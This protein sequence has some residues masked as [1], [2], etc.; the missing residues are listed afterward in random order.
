MNQTRIENDVNMD[1]RFIDRNHVSLQF[2]DNEILSGKVDAV[3]PLFIIFKS[4]DGGLHLVPWTS[5]VSIT[6]L[7]RKNPSVA[8]K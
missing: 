7:K 5:I 3:Y 8:E 4:D 2:I 6:K 1:V